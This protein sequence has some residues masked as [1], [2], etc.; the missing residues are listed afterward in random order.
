MKYWG[1]IVDVFKKPQNAFHLVIVL[2]ALILGVVSL[3]DDDLNIGLTGI[4]VVLSALTLIAI[5]SEEARNSEMEVFK[6]DICACIDPAIKSR[7]DIPNIIKVGENSKDI[8]II[9]QSLSSISNNVNFFISRLL[10]GSCIRLVVV[11]PNNNELISTLV[12]F[13]KNEEHNIR[14]NLTIFEGNI[15]K[16]K[17]NIAK[18]Q[19]IN[20][21]E[22]FII[23]MINY[24]PTMSFL[25]LDGN[26]ANG[27]IY[28][29]ML[30]YDNDTNERP[31]WFIPYGSQW[32]DKMKESCDK[33]WKNALPY[34]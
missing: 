25:M 26:K 34:Q 31:T 10:N 28:A 1:K 5:F 6:K 17:E 16:I 23:R 13:T 19:S 29:D 22:Q 30:L 8:L 27:A 9:G 32:Y 33:T 24:P 7:K 20:L 12:E 14:A 21:N 3:L 2:M 4:L 18:V 15:N 11:N